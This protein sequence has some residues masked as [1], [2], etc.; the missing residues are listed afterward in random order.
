[1]LVHILVWILEK[2]NARREDF[3]VRASAITRLDVHHGTWNT[4]PL[5]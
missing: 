3:L 5:L 4:R 2:W 1:M